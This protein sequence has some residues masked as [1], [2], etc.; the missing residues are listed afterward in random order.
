M[1]AFH[2]MQNPCGLPLLQ[3][4]HAHRGSMSSHGVFPENAHSYLAKNAQ[5][6]LSVTTG[7]SLR[8]I[9]LECRSAY[10]TKTMQP[11]FSYFE[12][13]KRGGAK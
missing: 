7:D 5:M 12:K 3:E 9:M 4:I 1:V 2:G 13:Y 8:S 6:N 10:N 11:G